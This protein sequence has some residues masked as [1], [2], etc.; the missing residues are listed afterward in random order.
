M[1][2]RELRVRYGERSVFLD[3]DSRS[4]GLSFPMKI[5]GALNQ[6]DVVLVIIGPTWLESLNERTDDSRDW[7]RYEV[8]QSLKRSWLPVV[9]IC[10]P[11]VDI[12]RPHQL[13]EELS[14]LGW[15]DGVTLDP[16]Q[17]FDSHLNRLLSDMERVLVMFQDQKEQL[18]L[19]RQGLVAALATR[20]SQLLEAERVEKE[21]LLFARFRLVTVLARL[22]HGR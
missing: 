21:Q 9:P 16:F 7:V 15:R 4:P 17:D 22:A 13:P 6:T 1:I 11:G 8:A 12:P 19:A 18:R 2:F 20:V 14:D 5:E 3:V 10:C